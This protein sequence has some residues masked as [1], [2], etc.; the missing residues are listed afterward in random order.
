MVDTYDEEP[1][2]WAELSFVSIVKSSKSSPAP[3]A[4]LRSLPAPR[5]GQETSIASAGDVLPDCAVQKPEI[6]V[7]IW[8]MLLPLVAT[9]MVPTRIDAVHPLP[10][11]VALSQ[12]LTIY[13]VP[14]RSEVSVLSVR[15]APVAS[16][17]STLKKL[18]PLCAVESVICC[19]LI[20]LELLVRVIIAG[21]SRGSQLKATMLDGEDAGADEDEV[22]PT[23]A[24]DWRVE[25]LL[26]ADEDDAL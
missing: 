16:V 3:S 21:F 10:A 1:P 18:P 9:V 26:E 15:V 17:D 5:G 14:L 22:V 2:L 12:S 7:Q 20:K 8:G 4:L 13:R 19:L 6:A 24:L 23:D 25:L 11:A